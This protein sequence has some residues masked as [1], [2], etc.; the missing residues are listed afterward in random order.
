LFVAEGAGQPGSWPA[1]LASA[2][3]LPFVWVESRTDSQSLPDGMG[4]TARHVRRV[5]KRDGWGLYLAAELED[6]DLS[7]LRLDG[8]SGWAPLAAALEI[9]AVGGRPSQ[10]VFSTGRWVDGHGI[11]GVD[12]VAGKA[13]AVHGLVDPSEAAVFFVPAQSVAPFG[14]ET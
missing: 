12:G 14:R 6:Y 4:E 8:R 7:G 13:Q 3:A 9:A 10:R 2:F 11:A 5:I 1:P